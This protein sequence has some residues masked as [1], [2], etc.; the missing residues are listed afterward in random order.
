M[1][2][3]QLG[4]RLFPVHQL[5]ETILYRRVYPFDFQTREIN[6]LI[7]AFEN[8]VE[9]F[10]RDIGQFHVGLLPQMGKQLIIVVGSGGI[11]PVGKG[12]HD[13]LWTIHR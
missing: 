13:V 9:V 6:L 10:P 1:N 2:G 5:D 11:E 12:L 4:I 7:L 3:F 8:Q